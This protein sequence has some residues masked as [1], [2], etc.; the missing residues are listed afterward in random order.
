MRVLYFGDIFGKP[1][2]QAVSIAIPKLLVEF[3]PDF[4]IGNAENATHGKG[5]NEEM[6]REFFSEGMDCIT[7]GNHVWD[8]PKLLPMLESDPRIIRPANY[9]NHPQYPNPGRGLTI[10]ESLR[11]KCKP[12][13]IVQVQGRVHMDPVECPFASFD[14]ELV[15]IR[16]SGKTNCIFVD[17]HGEATSE[18]MAFAFF[19]D[20]RV[21]AVVGS[22]S[23]VQTADERILPLGTAAITDVGMCG[24]FNSVIGMQK[25]LAIRK[26]ITKRP[27]K[28]EPAIGPG[29]YGAVIVDIDEVT[30]LATKIIRLRNV[31]A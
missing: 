20:G 3:A 10:L 19:V 29:G 21:S 14:K 27:T 28:L 25:D 18:K 7:L 22:H 11:S 9:P 6:A 8:Q 13:A 16:E 1:G 4:I 5:I 12:I 17:F 23:H 31:V 24:D 26:F 15:S 30:G 2:R